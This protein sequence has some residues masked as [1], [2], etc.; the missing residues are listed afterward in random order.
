I[1]KQLSGLTTNFVA[2]WPR[3]PCD[4]PALKINRSLRSRLVMFAIAAAVSPVFSASSVRVTGPLTRTACKVTRW[5]W[6]PARARLV[7]ESC[8]PAARAA[9]RGFMGGPF[10]RIQVHSLLW[11]Q[12]APRSN[13]VGRERQRAERPRQ[14]S[15]SRSHR[16]AVDAA[17]EFLQFQVAVQTFDELAP[18]QPEQFRPAMRHAAADQDAPRRRRQHDGV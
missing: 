3:A 9:S 1:E 2:G 16:I 10:F 6:S 7:P 5:L 12:R 13:R 14:R 11:V 8:G 4:R 15:Q 18:H 17:R